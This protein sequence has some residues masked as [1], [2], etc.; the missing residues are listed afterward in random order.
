LV[1]LVLHLA[2]ARLSAQRLG[3]LDLPDQV[4]PAVMAVQV[5]AVH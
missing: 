1:D 4:V 3:L 2:W 5:L